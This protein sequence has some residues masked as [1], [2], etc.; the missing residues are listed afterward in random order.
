[1]LESIIRQGFADEFGFAVD[2]AILNG[3]GAG[4]PL[5]I[6]NSPALV[7]ITRSVASTIAAVDI[8]KM[9]ARTINP[10]NAFWVVNQDI[11]PVL[12]ALSIS[13][14]T[15]G[16]SLVFQP[17]GGL[18]GAPYSTLIGRPII[19][20]ESAASYGTKSDI[21]LCNFGEGYVIVS[22][23]VE[24]ASSIH[25]KFD[26]DQST[27]RFVL[28]IDGQPTLNNSISP[29]KGATNTVSHFTTLS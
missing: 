28:R 27:F 7:T 5:G 1:M 23:P 19:V 4:M 11:F 26:T 2:E 18:S 22:K 25:V 15:A 17:A 6:M 21:S 24:S 20:S 3:T 10:N 8:F 9:W 29:F 16:G 13:V 12:Y 14:G